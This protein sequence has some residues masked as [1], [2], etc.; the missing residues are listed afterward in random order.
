MIPHEARGAIVASGLGLVLL[1]SPALAVD[2]DGDGLRDD[3]ET[4]YG[5]TDRLDP[6]TDGDGVVDSAEDLD[7]D[8]LGNLGEQR[9][10]T[11]PARWDTDGDGR[12]DGLEDHD[13]DGRKNFKEQDQRALPRG[14]RPRLGRASADK[15]PDRRRC[16]AK[17]GQAF[18]RT[19]VFGD[20]S[21][22]T[23]IV[24]VGD[25]AMTAYLTPF[26]QLAHTRGWRLTTMVKASCPPFLGL[27]GT[28]QWKIDRNRSCAKWRQNVI[29]RLKADPPD[30]IVYGFARYKLRTLKGT[31]VPAAKVPS[32]VQPAVK[33]T[34]M[35]LPAT[36]D[37]LVLGLVPRNKRG[38]I[39][40]LEA[41]VW[42]MSKC[43]S[44]R[45]PLAQRPWDRAVAKGALIGGG[46]Y[47]SLY[48]K[49]CSYDPCPV[50]QGKVLMWR[51][52]VHLSETFAQKLKPSIANLLDRK[53]LGSGS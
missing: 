28:L 42:S 40:C 53:L 34:L 41:H 11:H 33:K 49:V 21:S 6:D 14:L 46:T 10:G 44:P 38:L 22:Q 1:A 35:R 48:D 7:H 50:V 3:F 12:S 20:K 16:Q 18:V 51:D 43:L 2:S 9:F 32:V 26:K 15:Q 13:G 52:S 47:G 5:V 17:H 36:S 27:R 37:V 19:C 45:T 39:D 31:N 8:R 4:R 23:T 30:Y 24:L 29:R 25:S